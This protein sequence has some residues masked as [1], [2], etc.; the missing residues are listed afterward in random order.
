MTT[1]TAKNKKW[2]GR[3]ILVGCVIWVCIT[4]WGILSRNPGMFSQS[5][6]R[7]QNNSRLGTIGTVTYTASGWNGVPIPPGKHVKTWCITPNVRR[8]VRVNQDPTRVHDII[9]GQKV[10]LGDDLTYLEWQAQ[11]GQSTPEGKMGYELTPLN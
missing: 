4:F 8:R 10:Q 9:P 3:L 7:N 6:R 1:T 2:T 11:Q 5:Q